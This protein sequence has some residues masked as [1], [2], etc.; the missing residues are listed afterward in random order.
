MD[1]QTL[2]QSCTLVDAT[3]ELGTGLTGWQYGTYY[4]V[5]AMELR[6][7][8]PSWLT[9]LRPM[10]GQLTWLSMDSTWALM[11]LSC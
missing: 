6:P 1:S 10:E 11:W 3:M 8:T 9:S 5:S 2:P 4:L 7:G